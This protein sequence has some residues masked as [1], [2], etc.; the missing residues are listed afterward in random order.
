MLRN[1]Q[2]GRQVFVVRS[3][4]AVAAKTNRKAIAS[5]AVVC[6]TLWLAVSAP[7]AEA[8]TLPLLRNATSS[9]VLLADDFESP[10]APANPVADTGIWTT[11]ESI[12]TNVGNSTLQAFEGNQSVRL[13]RNTGGSAN[14]CVARGGSQ[15]GDGR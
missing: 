9:T 6:A 1:V 10:A 11:F 3:L 12:S 15:S 14:R 2:S 8:V 4:V 7:T 5:V 13:F